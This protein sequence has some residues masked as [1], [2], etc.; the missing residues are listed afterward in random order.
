MNNPVWQDPKLLKLWMLCLLEATHKEHEQLVGK[1]IIKLQPGEFV[2]GRF[3]LAKTYNEGAKK[4]N[5]VEERTL[6]RWMKMLETYDFLSIK[7]NTKYSVITIKNW[8]L[9]QPNVQPVSNKC[10]ADVQPMST[11]N[12]GNNVNNDNKKDI[13]NNPN[14]RIMDFWDLNGFGYNNINAKNK[15][16]MYLDEGL[17]E[18]VILRA[19]EIACDR[20]K[21]S[22]SYV[23]SVL[24]DWSKRGLK[25]IKLV[26][27]AEVEFK[28]KN[29][30]PRGGY[31]KKAIRVEGDPDEIFAKQK[32]QQ[33][34]KSAQE[35]SATKSE[36]D[37]MLKALEN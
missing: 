19:L 9:Y 27:A 7:S 16:L 34:K 36:I 8:N 32:E 30:K 1:Q 28:Q 15:L 29:Q 35:I 18:D 11:N 4:A 10:P 24:N 37:E 21:I 20:N 12:N 31:A 17:E 5:L 3:S 6:W 2:T 22:Y 23:Q 13:N 26:E 33:Q 14:K 25:T